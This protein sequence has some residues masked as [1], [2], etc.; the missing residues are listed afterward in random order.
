MKRHT[1][2][3]IKEIFNMFK[4]L[5]KNGKNNFYTYKIYKSSNGNFN[6][7]NARFFCSINGQKLIDKKVDEIR[8]RL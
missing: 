5:I 1:I 4:Y 3:Q 7:K 8:K 6:I 2:M